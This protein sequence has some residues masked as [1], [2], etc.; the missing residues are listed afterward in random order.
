LLCCPIPLHLDID[1]LQVPFVD[2]PLHRLGEVIVHGVERFLGNLATAQQPQLAAQA[3]LIG[4]IHIAPVAAFVLAAIGQEIIVTGSRI[5]KER[6]GNC[7]VQPGQRIVAGGHNV[8][9]AQ[10]IAVR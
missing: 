7:V 8:Q 5:G 1:R 4:Q 3:L 9:A 10:G 6:D 2:Q